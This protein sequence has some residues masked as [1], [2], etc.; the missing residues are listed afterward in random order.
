MHVRIRARS[1]SDQLD[2]AF[3][4]TN[5]PVQPAVHIIVNPTTR[6]PKPMAVPIVVVPTTRPPMPTAVHIIVHVRPRVCVWACATTAAAT[7][8][9]G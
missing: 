9:H 2:A 7:P 1:A 4:E 3:A 8:S 5:A 6:P